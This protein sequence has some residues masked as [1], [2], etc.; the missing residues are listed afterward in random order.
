MKTPS[1][2]AVQGKRWRKLKNMWKS[3]KKVLDKLAEVG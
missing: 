1:F 2:Q 3:G